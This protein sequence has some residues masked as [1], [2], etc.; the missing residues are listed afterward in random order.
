[1]VTGQGGNGLAAAQMAREGLAR[2]VRGLVAW[3]NTRPA[4]L[5]EELRRNSKSQGR[6]AH[7]RLATE[8]P[9]RLCR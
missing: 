5:K 4:E 9:A 7:G 2:T 6:S 1:M 8:M 3:D